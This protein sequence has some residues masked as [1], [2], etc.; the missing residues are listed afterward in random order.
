MNF[1]RRVKALTPAWLQYRIDLRRCDAEERELA[2][3]QP[4]NTREAHESGEM[5]DYASRY[6]ALREWN[7]SLI[8]ANYR[9]I[10]GKLS[11]PMPDINDILMY[12]AAEMEKDEQSTK[13]LTSAGEAYLRSAIREERKHR[14]DVV[15]YWF[16]IAVG[17]IGAL[18]GLVSAFK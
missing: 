12:E 11:I 4:P 17:V 1:R 16:G 15:T 7:R 8:T 10:A 6:F 2:K 5:F 9:R 3:N 18:T 13:Y 14:R